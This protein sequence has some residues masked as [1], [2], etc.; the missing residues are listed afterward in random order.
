MISVLFL[1]VLMMS[2]CTA[3]DASYRDFLEN[4]E[5]VYPGRTDSMQFK[6]GLNRAAI[7]SKMSTDARVVKM[8]ITWGFG[9]S[10]ETDVLPSDIANHKEV[11]IPNIEE[12]IYTFDIRTFDIEGNSS[13][14]SEIVG[15]VYG[16]TYVANLNNRIISFMNRNIND[17]LVIRWFSETQDTTLVGTEVRY[18]NLAGD[19]TTVFTTQDL[20]STLLVGV[21]PE[22]AVSFRNLYK[23]TSLAIDTFYAAEVNVQPMDYIQPERELYPRTTW[24]VIDFSSENNS[25]NHGANN[26]IDDNTATFWIA[27]FTNPGTNYPNHFFT[28]DMMNALQVDGF[29]FA[30]KNGDR[31]IREMEIHISNDNT[32]WENLGLFGLADIDRDYQYLNLPEQKVF[33]YFKVVPVSGHDSQQAPGLA[34]AGT[35]RHVY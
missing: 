15:R 28:I 23:P 4:T 1:T 25:S 2:G 7:R 14:R 17:E 26:L 13:M 22:S 6:P 3:I 19:S 12:G 5:K 31:K 11:V 20:D 24:S 34:E 8:R 30:Q 32:N 16:D 9:N 33:R 10:Y 21:D 29:T 18:K 35:F 27:R